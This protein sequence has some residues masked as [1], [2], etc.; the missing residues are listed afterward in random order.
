M[1][2]RDR[3]HST[4]HIVANPE[5]IRIW[6]QFLFQ[7]HPEFIWRQSCGELELSDEALRALQA[8]SKLTEVVDDVEYEE[9]APTRNLVSLMSGEML[10]SSRHLS[11]DFQA[12]VVFTFDRYPCLYLK[13]KDFMKIKQDGKIQ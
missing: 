1:C 2:I 12:M 8:Q 10:L 7:S 4:K 11:L 13:A 3:E 6:L 9:T 5:K